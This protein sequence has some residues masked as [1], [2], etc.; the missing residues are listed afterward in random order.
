M[1][2]FLGEVIVELSLQDPW[3]LTKVK[4]ASLLPQGSLDMSRKFY[5]LCK[6]IQTAL[7]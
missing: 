5:S 7:E 3:A 4:D 1:A 2:A 6:E